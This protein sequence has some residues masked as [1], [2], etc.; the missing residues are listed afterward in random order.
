MAPISNHQQEL[1]RSG[2]LRNYN[3]FHF[4]NQEVSVKL[5]SEIKFDAAILTLTV[6]CHNPYFKSTT[7]PAVKQFAGTATQASKEAASRVSIV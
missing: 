2:C 6:A 1:E 7:G 5:E 3:S 4:P